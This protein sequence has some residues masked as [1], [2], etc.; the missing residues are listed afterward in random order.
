V[1]DHGAAHTTVIKRVKGKGHDDG[2][3]GA[4]KVAFADFCLA[5]LCLFLVMWLLAVRQADELEILLKASGG[6]I[7]DQGSSK[8]DEAFGGPRGSLIAREPLP[9]DGDTIAPRKRTRGEV[10]QQ[11]TKSSSQ[12][13]RGK[14]K[15]ASSSPASAP[16]APQAPML[17]KSLYETH[18]DMQ[19]LADVLA[20]LSVQSGLAANLQTIIT[21]YGLRVILHDTDKQGMFQRGSAVANDRF[22]ALLGKLGPVFS[23][24]RNQM[25]VVGHTDSVQYRDQG[26]K[27]K[28]NWTL[29]SDRAV[30]AR[31]Y[32]MVGG[33]PARSVLQVV[34]LAD[35]APFN[36]QDA[37]AAENRRIELLI[38]T[39][40]QAQNVSAMFG[41]PGRT[42]PLIQNVSTSLPDGDALAS[43]RGQLSTS[44]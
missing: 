4:W 20:R 44:R 39:L 19:E 36:V 23:Q 32:L 7:L 33:M 37:G 3:G 26:P 40:A 17:S 28:S 10:A 27:A 25:L 12:S 38:L 14:G 11:G 6:N 9:S 1:A 15:E 29:S 13:A 24:I 35:R 8:T 5:L 21:P 34:G 41:A 42:E 31:E 30:A 22:I 2:H 43:L 16:G 18:A